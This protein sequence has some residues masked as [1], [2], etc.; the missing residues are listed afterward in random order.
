MSVAI[1]K[2]IVSWDALSDMVA[3][4]AEK[5][6][7][8]FDL[9]LAITRG[10]MVPGGLARPSTITVLPKQPPASGRQ[11]DAETAATPGSVDSRSRM[12]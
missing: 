1:D 10:G 11:V 9:M 2:D 7:A 12:A 3:D 4:L 6:P 5:V 8:D